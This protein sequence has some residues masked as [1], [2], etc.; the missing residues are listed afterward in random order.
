MVPGRLH[1]TKRYKGITAL[2]TAALLVAA[3]FL[4]CSCGTHNGV[5]DKS[6]YLGE[7]SYDSSI[8]AMVYEDM[9]GEGKG[10]QYRKV[11]DYDKLIAYSPEPVCLYFYGG[12]S[13]DTSGVTAAVE[14][15]AENYYD[16]I[17]IVSVDADQETELTSHFEIAALPDFILL[18]NGSWTASFSNNDG[19]TWTAADLEQWIAET[20]ENP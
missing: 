15:I 20:I 19:K 2:L 18:E 1:C 13:S 3:S 16:R 4:L 10:I 6:A 12:L 8:S 11:T 14:Q 7:Y 9:D 17:L 5:A